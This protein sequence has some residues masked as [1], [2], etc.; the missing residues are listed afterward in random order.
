ML[1]YVILQKAAE[2][3]VEKLISEATSVSATTSASH[4][5]SAAKTMN[6]FALQVSLLCSLLVEV[7]LWATLF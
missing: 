4:T 2:V 5:A 3:D 1:L 6:P 7:L